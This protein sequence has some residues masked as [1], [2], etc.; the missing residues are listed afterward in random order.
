M[1]LDVIKTFYQIT[2]III[3]LNYIKAQLAFKQKLLE[4]L[5]QIESF[6]IVSEQ[7]NSTLSH[8]F[9]Y[10]TV[11]QM[12]TN[13]QKLGEILKPSL[14]SRQYFFHINLF[15]LCSILSNSFNSF[16]IR[17]P[18]EVNIAESARTRLPSLFTFTWRCPTKPTYILP[19]DGTNHHSGTV[20]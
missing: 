3:Y 16:P 12:G 9:L 8:T 2:T 6:L 20:K 5:Q 10:I 11:A 14:Q 17:R 7:T 4:N 13:K 19:R 15:L 1:T 18:Q